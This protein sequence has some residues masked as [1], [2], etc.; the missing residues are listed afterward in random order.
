VFNIG[1]DRFGTMYETLDALCRHAG[2]GATVRS[3]PAAPAALAMKLS[4]ALGV[5][6]FAPYHWLMYSQSM[7]FDIEHARTQLGWEPQWSTD[8]MFA[9]SYDWYLAHRDTAG[10]G[11]SHHRRSAKPGMLTIVKRATGLLPRPRGAT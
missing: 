7:W 11:A 5:T 4:S 2:T 1:T 9:Q 8:A 3:L 10:S 6:P